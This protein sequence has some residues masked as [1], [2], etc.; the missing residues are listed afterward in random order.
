MIPVQRLVC[1]LVIIILISIISIPAA[2]ASEY[3]VA[4]DG[5]EFTSIQAAINQAFPGDS[6]IVNSG[7]Y[8]EN[9][10]LDKRIILSGFDSGGGPPIIDPANKG[11]AMEILADGCRVEGF[12][13]QNIELLNGMRIKS[14][15]NTIRHNTFLNNSKGIL[16]ESTTKNTI[17]GNNISNSSQVGDRA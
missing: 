3:T 15:E 1:F 4:P 17:Y 10:L 2:H 14:S 13:L 5:A 16:L 11:S 12:T 9:L 6:I 8:P 7:T